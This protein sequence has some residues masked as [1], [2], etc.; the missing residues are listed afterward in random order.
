MKTDFTSVLSGFWKLLWFIT[1]EEN[2]LRRWFPTVFGLNKISEVAAC[3]I[4]RH[5]VVKCASV[6]FVPSGSFVSHPPVFLASEES[7][8]LA[9]GPKDGHCFGFM[10]SLVLKL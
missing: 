8:F 6:I 9:D 4:G 5:L 10:T 2:M 3:I 1:E 7:V